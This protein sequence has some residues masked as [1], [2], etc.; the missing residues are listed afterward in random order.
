MLM[1]QKNTYSMIN[2]KCRFIWDISNWRER[3]WISFSAY[4]GLEKIQRTNDFLWLGTNLKC[5]AGDEYVFVWKYCQSGSLK[6][7]YRERVRV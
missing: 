5:K 1:Q 7:K 2:S 3:N 4:W 6:V